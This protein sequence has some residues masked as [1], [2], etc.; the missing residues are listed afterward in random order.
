MNTSSLTSLPLI[1]LL[2]I[3]FYPM[4]LPLRYLQ[5][6][7]DTVTSG[8]MYC[9]T[10]KGRAPHFCLHFSF[11]GISHLHPSTATVLPPARHRSP[12]HQGRRPGSGRGAAPSARDTA[13]YQIKEHQSWWR[14]MHVV[15]EV[16]S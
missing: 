11:L 4:S 10:R 6:D 16:I 8:V 12:H 13:S 5:R 14:P 1:L 3:I 7:F 2:Q 9:M 15:A